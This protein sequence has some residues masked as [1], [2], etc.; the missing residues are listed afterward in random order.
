MGLA[1]ALIIEQP[2]EVNLEEKG[3]LP[4]GEYRQALSS[5]LAVL[6]EE[7]NARSAGLLEKGGHDEAEMLMMH[8]AML[9]DNDFQDS[10]CSFVEKG[11]SLAASV[12]RGAKEMGQLLID[13]GDA[14][15][16]ER[17]ADAADAAF[18][19]V[20]HISGAAFPNLSCL[21]EPV[22]VVADDIAAS[23]L[24]GAD[25]E[26]IRGIALSRGSKTAHSS[27]LAASLEI[28]MLVNCGDLCGLY[29]HV[30]KNP[31][32]HIFLNAVDGCLNYC[33]S[34]GEKEAAGKTT[35]AY[36]AERAALEAYKTLEAR[37]KDG[38]RIYVN[39]NIVETQAI[40][41]ILTYGGD[42]V[43][44]FRTEFMFMN[45][46]TLPAEDEQYAAYYSAAKK[47]KGRPLVIRTIDIGA[48][49]P[50]EAL[51]LDPEENPF[52]GYRAIRICLGNQ[53]LFRTQLRAIVRASVFGN[54][55]I[56]I[57]MISSM[58][59]LDQTI[60]VL[61]SV[62]AELDHEGT[63]Y[64][65]NI[66]LGIMVEIPSTAILADDFI[67]KVDFFSIGSNDLTQYTLAVDRMNKK[68]QYLYNSLDPAV[69]RLIKNVIDACVRAGKHCSLCGEMAAQPDSLPVLIGMGLVSISVNPASILP[70]KKLIES[71]D[72]GALRKTHTAS[73][74]GAGPR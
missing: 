12:M 62:K 27:I 72:Y 52:L 50:V 68:V 16:A 37:T 73:G 43:G 65:K 41:N 19:L 22:I 55:R 17:A 13:S 66:P 10:V 69:L 29:D 71:L 61:E 36:T 63:A 31:D 18:R 34:D 48:D 46:K 35:A 70:L 44:L 30:R 7:L 51:R 57:P 24:M 11:Y 45:K 38:R 49:K 1:K 15:M 58:R 32:G 47:L 4:A 9:Q 67:R 59:E 56:L 33:M 64:D 26:H 8:L 23:L 5:H 3:T 42:G 74:S 20:C 6:E 2:L 60:A 40:S 28:P 25:Y 21:N 14:Y 54:V 39:G 53:D